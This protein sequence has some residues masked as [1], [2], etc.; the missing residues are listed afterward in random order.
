MVPERTS[1]SMTADSLEV[2]D[3]ESFDDDFEDSASSFARQLGHNG[4]INNSKQ[5]RYRTT[6]T[7]F[8]LQEL[9]K[10]FSKTHYPDVFTRE[11][12]AMRIH[13]TEA[14]IQVW[15]QNRRA[16]WRKTD[17][18]LPHPVSA[19]TP[20]DQSFPQVQNSSSFSTKGHSQ[21]HSSQSAERSNMMGWLPTAAGLPGVVGLP[22]V[23]ANGH[24]SHLVAQQK[25]PP[26]HSTGF[27]SDQAVALWN[28]RW[29]QQMAVSSFFQRD[30]P[31][32]SSGMTPNLMSPFRPDLKNFYHQNSALGNLASIRDLDVHNFGAFCSMSKNNLPN[33]NSSL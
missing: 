31:S 25:F 18:S 32:W 11:E 30:A 8:Q 4:T 10:C 29:L 12:L 9:E 16:K 28:Q 15:F 13:L 27:F 14:R 1:S 2:D 17:K 3:K 19:D 22:A 21:F 24:S 26:R 5:R 20:T 6:F 23:A 7:A 33:Y